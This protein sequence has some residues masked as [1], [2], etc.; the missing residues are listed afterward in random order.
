[1]LLWTYDPQLTFIGVAIALLNVV[2]MRVVIR[3]RATRTQKLRADS[4][5]LTNTSYTGLQLIETMKATGGE[6]GYFRRWAGQHAT[7][8]EEQ[9][10]L[11]VPSACAGRRRP[12]PRDAQQRA[13]PA[14][15]AACGRSRAISRSVCWSP[16]RRW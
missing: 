6:N 10:R 1:M 8:L 2:A 11:G 13:D 7:T 12:D 9:Q 16:S 5:R 14:G 4:A 3:L 15:S